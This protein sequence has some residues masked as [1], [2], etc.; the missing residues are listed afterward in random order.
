MAPCWGCSGG[1]RGW[2]GPLLGAAV[3][4]ALMLRG[5]GEEAGPGA[6]LLPPQPAT[7]ND[8]NCISPLLP[9]CPFVF[10]VM[11]F[12]CVTLCL[13]IYRCCQSQDHDEVRAVI[14]RRSDLPGDRGVLIVCHA[15][16]KKKAYSFFLVQ[17]GVG[18][19]V[20]INRGWMRPGG[21]QSGPK[22][23]VSKACA[24]HKKKA[25]SFFLVQVGVGVGLGA[26]A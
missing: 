5:A 10:F 16:H 14:P 20:F 25:Y 13:F 7:R 15:T 19:G 6:Q 3:L 12:F 22:S 1:G 24:T 4:C 17:V 9:N 8:K 18:V 23:Y 11:S 21:A 26:S 2:G